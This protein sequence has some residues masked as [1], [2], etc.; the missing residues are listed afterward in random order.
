[1]VVLTWFL[2]EIYLRLMLI[3]IISARGSLLSFY[4]WGDISLDLGT[5]ML[6]GFDSSI[7]AVS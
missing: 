7:G 2:K 1:M 4:L 3:S 5:S 6:A